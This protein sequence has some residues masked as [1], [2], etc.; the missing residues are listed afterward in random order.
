[1]THPK[2][3]AAPRDAERRCSH[4]LVLLRA[5]PTPRHL[6]SRRLWQSTA[7]SVSGPRSRPRW[8]EAARGAA[9]QHQ[10]GS[11]RRQSPSMRPTLHREP[12]S[13]VSSSRP[14]SR[15]A[16]CPARPREPTVRPPVRYRRFRAAPW[17]R[18]CSHPPSRRR[19]PACSMSV[20][21]PVR[22]VRRRCKD[23][24]LR[25]WCSHPARRTRAHAPPHSWH[26]ACS[27]RGGSMSGIRTIRCCRWQSS[28]AVRAARPTRCCLPTP[29]PPPSV[30]L[31]CRA[32]RRPVQVW[33]AV[34]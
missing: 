32:R 22:R 18:E 1:M 30:C 7:G 17:R 29:R 24:A 12:P 28:R 33:S 16:A 6:H 23:A 8:R 25:V 5:A 14:V 27:C 15:P 11:S 31:R 9:A 10:T 3:W 2:P 34:R 4:A 26:R 20:H 21:R 13:G 19:T